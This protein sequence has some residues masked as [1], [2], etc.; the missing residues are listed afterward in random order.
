MNRFTFS[1][2]FSI[3]RHKI[4]EKT[5][6]LQK[7]H[8]FYFV[9]SQICT[10]FALAKAKSPHLVRWMRGLVNGLQNRLHPFESG[11]HLQEKE[12]RNKLFRRSFLWGLV[13]MEG[14]RNKKRSGSI[15]DRRN[16]VEMEGIEP[17]SKQ[18][19]HTLSTCL[20]LSLVFVMQQDQDHQL[21]PYPLKVSSAARGC[22]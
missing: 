6:S 1:C 9:V 8:L 10:T 2:A 17:S 13:E 15:P 11:T 20:F 12:R 18:G 16:L 21:H 19:S 3:K 5:T 7:K 4:R 22:C 14:P